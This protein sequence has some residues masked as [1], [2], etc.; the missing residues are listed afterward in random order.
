MG[1]RRTSILVGLVI[2][3]GGLWLAHSR[4]APVASLELA[5]S[6]VE[7]VSLPQRTPVLIQQKRELPPQ[8]IE[9]QKVS[10]PRVLADQLKA[11]FAA[12]A[13]HPNTEALAEKLAKAEPNSYSA[14]KAVALSKFLRLTNP[15]EG[16]MTGEEKEKVKSALD[17]AEEVGHAGKEP[18]SQLEDLKL[19]FAVLESVKAKKSWQQI[20]DQVEQFGRSRPDSSSVPYFQAYAQCRM[21][22]GN[23]CVGLLGQS[24]EK[25]QNIWERQVRIQLLAQVQQG[26]VKD[27]NF[28]LQFN[29]RF[30]SEN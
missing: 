19:G 21:G 25:T 27:A 23:E 14:A 26:H 7:P 8:A 20:S 30:S 28:T 17:H 24:I 1:I 3:V 18:D 9:D 29:N 13:S 4:K 6:R 2:A 11:G 15:K 22:N 10:D 5:D 16:L 12:D